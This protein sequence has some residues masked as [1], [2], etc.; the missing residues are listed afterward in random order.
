MAEQNE[1]APAVARRRVR[2][3]AFRIGNDFVAVR[4][5]RVSTTERIEPGTPIDKSKFRRFHVQALFRRRMIGT[6]GSPWTQAMLA[7]VGDAHARPEM[8]AH[9]DSAPAPVSEP[10][11]TLAADLGL[12]FDEDTETDEAAALLDD[13]DDDEPAD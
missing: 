11:E 7:R 1:K 9:A 12:D 10:S 13:D 2:R 3:E 8:V 5:I 4:Y 6:V